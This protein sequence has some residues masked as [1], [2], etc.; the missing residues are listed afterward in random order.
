MMQLPVTATAFGRISFSL[1]RTR[2]DPWAPLR[3][4]A[5]SRASASRA[6]ERSRD[7]DTWRFLMAG[8]MVA[9]SAITKVDN[10][11]DMGKQPSID[12]HR[13]DMM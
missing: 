11:K 7:A 1:Y 3:F 13:C 5:I 6:V 10:E 2:S 4:S 12:M 8:F 9:A